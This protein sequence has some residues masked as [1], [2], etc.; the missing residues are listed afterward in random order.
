MPT[1]RLIAFAALLLLGCS[2]G[3]QP[4]LAVFLDTTTGRDFHCMDATV[5]AL[6]EGGGYR[7]TCVSD[8]DET[9]ELAYTTDAHGFTAID[10][11]R[12]HSTR[13]SDPIV[14][15]GHADA[16]AA[17]GQPAC[18]PD[19]GDPTQLPRALPMDGEHIA[20]GSHSVLLLAPCGDAILQIGR[21]LNQ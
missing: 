9:L 13:R 19:G 10:A 16:L 15:A 17:A 8:P 3:P 6:P 21:P 11:I 2:D 18:T 20:Y 4:N 7:F 1:H 14:V 12:V 5:T